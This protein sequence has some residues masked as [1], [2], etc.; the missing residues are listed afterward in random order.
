M[1]IIILFIIKLVRV[2]VNVMPFHYVDHLIFDLFFL[3]L[4]FDVNFVAILNN[5]KSR[6]LNEINGS[7]S[8]FNVLQ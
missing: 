4:C 6:R 3:F 2:K 5:E 7:P 1:S 8:N